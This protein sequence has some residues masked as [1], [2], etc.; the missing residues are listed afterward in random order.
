MLGLVPNCIYFAS[1]YEKRAPS[2]WG[3]TIRF[4]IYFQCQRIPFFTTLV[5][6]DESVIFSLLSNNPK[7]YERRIPPLPL[8]IQEVRPL[9]FENVQW[10]GNHH[11]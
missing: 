1:Y 4:Y 7:K 2:Q 9:E 6:Q 5:F 8:E 11:N 3:V 10:R